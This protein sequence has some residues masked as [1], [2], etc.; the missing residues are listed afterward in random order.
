VEFLVELTIELPPLDRAALAELESR[1][2]AR[3]RELIAA[4]N[5]KHI[6]RLPGQRANISVYEVRD[7]TELHDLLVSLP[8]WPY[9][10][11]RVTPLAVH[12]L[13]R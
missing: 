11:A 5:L 2:F 3:G 1:E 10:V 8:L 12:P 9:L 7:A 13:Y 4:G 6:W